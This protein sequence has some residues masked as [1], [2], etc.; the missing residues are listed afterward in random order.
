MNDKLLYFATP[1]AAFYIDH[2]AHYLATLIN[3][4]HSGFYFHYPPLPTESSQFDHSY[5]SFSAFAEFAKFSSLQLTGNH[6]DR[7]LASKSVARLV[8]LPFLLG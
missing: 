2:R 3:Y 5:Q 4:L 7:L 8:L 6:S 1:A